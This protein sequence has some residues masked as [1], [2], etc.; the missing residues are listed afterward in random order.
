MPPP[1][2]P[3]PHRRGKEN[4]RPDGYDHGYHYRAEGPLPADRYAQ[5]GE[6]YAGNGW[7][8]RPP[9]HEDPRSNGWLPMRTG[10]QPPIVGYDYGPNQSL[11][12]GHDF[13]NETELRVLESRCFPHSAATGLGP[14]IQRPYSYDN[15]GGYVAPRQYI[16]EPLPMQTGYG[17]GPIEPGYA[18]RR[19]PVGPSSHPL[20]LPGKDAALSYDHQPNEGLLPTSHPAWPV[21]N[22]HKELKRRK[23]QDYVERLEQETL[24]AAESIPADRNGLDFRD[25]EPMGGV[26]VQAQEPDLSRKEANDT[27]RRQSFLGER[28]ERLATDRITLPPPLPA[29]LLT[30]THGF[31]LLTPPAVPESRVYQ[32]TQED[33]GLSTI[34][35]RPNEA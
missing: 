30:P 19:L 25:R 28:R 22:H 12:G 7:D 3:I 9:I 17:Y 16:E 5:L 24:G 18:P 2:S 34:W 13:D 6:T 4:I 32:Q 10:I 27:L 8:Y 29:G 1:P 21:E 26:V 14:V 23:R 33:S 11:P 15:V 35:E 20:W 31:T